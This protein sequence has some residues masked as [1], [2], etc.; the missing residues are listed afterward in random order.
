MAS[1]STIQAVPSCKDAQEKKEKIAAVGVASNNGDLNNT[2]AMRFVELPLRDSHFTYQ[3][4]ALSLSE[5]DAEIR[6]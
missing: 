1:L 4:L 6:A 3:S 5:E 2:S